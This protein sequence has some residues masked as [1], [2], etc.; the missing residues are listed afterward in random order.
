[1]AL[2]NVH[3]F[4]E[5]LQLNTEMSVILPQKSSRN[6]NAIKN[7][8]GKFPTLYLLHG[9]SDDHTAWIRNTSI[10]RY[11]EE[12]GIAVVMPN[13]NLSFY[14]NTTYGQNYYTF[15]AKELPQIARELFPD[16][17]NKR[18]DNFI[19]GLSMGGYG[20]LKIALTESDSFCA[21]ASLSGALNMGE[22]AI[23]RVIEKPIWKSFFQGIFGDLTKIAGSEND[24]LELA[25]RIKISGK[26]IPEIYFCCGTEDFLYQ[27]NLKCKKCFED[28]DMEFTYE[29]GPGDHQWQYWDEKIKRV[30][31]WL[32]IAK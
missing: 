24:I 15:A 19:A 32:P 1:M 23:R 11:V 26:K 20:A 10:E 16:L 14:T 4:S 28:L 2:F 17:S 7:K 18:E 5:V 29:E 8:D 27:D 9:L 6:L 13:V 25:K 22:E 12:Y 30:L 31:N 21:A 3:F